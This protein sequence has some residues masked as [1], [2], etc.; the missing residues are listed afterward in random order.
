MKCPCVPW[1][2][3]EALRHEPARVLRAILPTPAE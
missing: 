1:Y 3:F 2:H